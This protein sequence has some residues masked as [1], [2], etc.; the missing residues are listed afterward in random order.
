LPALGKALGTR[1]SGN[2]DYL[3]AGTNNVSRD[4][5]LGHG[6]P[7]TAGAFFSTKNNLIQ[8][9][10]LG[11]PEGFAW[12]LEGVLPSWSRAKNLLKYLSSYVLSSLGVGENR[13]SPHVDLLT[14]DRVTKN[15]MLYLGMGTDAADG[16]INLTGRGE[17]NV[18][19]NNAGSRQMFDEMRDAMRKISEA[20]GGTFVDSLLWR[21]PLRKLFTAHPLGGCVMADDPQQG[22]V[23]EYG[24][25]WGY[26]N[27]YVADAAII[28]TAV[29]VNP[30]ATI[31]ALAE[32]VAFHMIHARDMQHGDAQTPINYPSLAATGS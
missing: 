27:L 19:W 18:D 1:F 6:L 24:E 25:V 21:W 31:T 2:G 26:P 30:S 8:I 4:V 12:Y 3:L 10:D 23:N 22:V 9:Q 7:I 16:K 13:L 32:R 15:L 28:P 14:Q 5:D 20:A 29:V 17:I 11:T